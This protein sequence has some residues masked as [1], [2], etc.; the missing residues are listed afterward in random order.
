MSDVATTAQSAHRGALDLI[1]EFVNTWEEPDP[2]TDLLTSPDVL[3]RWL[4]SRRLLEAGERITTGAE[5]DRA[6]ALREALRALMEA[7]HDGDP[8][9]ADAIE[10]LRVEA[11]RIPLRLTFGRGGDASMEPDATGLDRAL[12]RLLVGV[13]RAMQD[14]E[15]ERLKVC[16]SDTCIAAF[17]DASKNRSGRFCS[18][19]C[20]NV[21]K[22]R[23]Y[24]ARQRGGSG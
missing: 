6:V 20:R 2:A 21:T 18:D 23:R 9:P 8:P 12:G 5:L 3:G 17:H 11:D 4:R 19:S 16:R 13:L 15:W 24:R 14:G 7:N 1:E 10:S 22:V